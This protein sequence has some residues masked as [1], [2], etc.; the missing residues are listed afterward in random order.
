MCVCVC[1]H[2]LTL[3]LEIRIFYLRIGGVGRWVLGNTNVL[4]TENNTLYL[5]TA[6]KPI[7]RQFIF[8]YMSWP[9]TVKV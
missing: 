7:A 5:R 8:F 6:P 9:F 4:R 1:V 2:Q 3:T